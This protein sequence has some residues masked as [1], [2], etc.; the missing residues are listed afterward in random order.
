MLPFYAFYSM[1][2]FQRIGDL[3]W[4]AGDI[5]ARGF[6]M[7]VPLVAP[8]L[9]VKVCSTKMAIAI[10]LRALFQTATLMILLTAMKW[11]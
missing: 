3:A 10:S 11:R 2:G 6:L 8:L 4:A 7:G 9:M 5:R 1:F